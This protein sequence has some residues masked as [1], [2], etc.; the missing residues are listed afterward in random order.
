MSG[1]PQ[2]P[3]RYRPEAIVIAAIGLACTSALLLAHYLLGL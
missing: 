2:T 3:A 1:V